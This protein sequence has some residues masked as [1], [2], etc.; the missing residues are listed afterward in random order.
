MKKNQSEPSN[1]PKK[2]QKNLRFVLSF[3]LLFFVMPMGIT[4]FTHQYHFGKRIVHE[5]NYYQYL[6]EENPEFAREPVTFLSNEGNQLDGAFFYQEGLKNAKGLLVWVHGMGV[7]Y[8]NYLGEIQYFT[9]EGYVVFSFNNTG[10]DKSQGESLKGL[11]Q[12]PL[13]LQSALVYLDL[14]DEFREIPLVLIGHSWGGF[15]VAT[16]SQLE[17]PR[18]VDGIVTLAAFW[19]N[20]NVIEDIAAYYVGDVITLLVPYL[21]LYER[22]LF[23]DNAK[24]NAISGLENTTAPVLMIHSE[25]DVVVRYDRN[26]LYFQEYFNQNP[27]FTFRSYEDAGHKLSINNSSYQRIHDIMHHQ[28]DLDETDEHYQELEEE[29]LSLIQDYNPLV[30]SDILNF[31]TGISED[32]LK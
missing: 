5:N 19:K 20:I 26:F 3:L 13:D 25:D 1:T 10:V 7:N 21:T 16:V 18:E 12:A 29:R 9:K 28:M 24:L 32:F 22:F 4:Y 27:R 11:I 30:M 14:F 15:S 6:I 17:I 31:L 8:E 2:Q 23:G